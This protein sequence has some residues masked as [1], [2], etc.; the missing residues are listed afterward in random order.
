MYSMPGMARAAFQPVRQLPDNRTE[1]P[2]HTLSSRFARGPLTVGLAAIALLLSASASAQTGT[3]APQI[4][5]RAPAVMLV[6]GN[7]Q[8]TELRATLLTRTPA[9]RVAA[10]QSVLGSIVSSSN[11]GAVTSQL[12]EGVMVVAVGDRT[13]LVLV[14][15]DVD[16]LTGETLEQKGAAAASRL[17]IAVAEQLELR[18]PARL[19]V[20]AVQSV[21]ATIVFVLLLLAIRRGYRV[22]S[23]RMPEGAEAKLQRFSAGDLQLVRA[24][25]AAD[26]LRGFISLVAGSIAVFLTYSWVTFV[27]RRFP[28]TRPWGESLREFLL[29]RLAGVGLLI[30][31]WLPDLFT[32]IVIVLVTR[33]ASR[34]IYV[35]FAAA[36]QDRLKIPAIHPETAP[37]TRRLVIALLWISAFVAS[38]PYLPGSQSDAFKGVSVFV[39]LIVS[40]GSSGIVGQAMSGLTLTYSRAVRIGDFVKIGDVEGT[41]AHLGSLS[42][43]IKTERRED[44]TIPNSVVVSTPITN[45][46]RFADAEGVLNPTTVTIGYDVPWRQVHAML[47]LAAE[48]T[49]NIKR[50]PAPVVRQTGLGNVSV[51]YALLVCLEQPLL[52]SPTLGALRANILDVFNEFGVQIMVPSYEGDPAAP[53]VVRREEWFAAPA[54]PRSVEPFVDDTAAETR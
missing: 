4:P 51:E 10:A 42:T 31:Q 44:V 41:V 20:S 1:T 11:V 32:I 25:K 48:R 16:E 39:G 49:S 40:L 21:A 52:R 19:A 8:I 43:K 7:R 29:S 38:Y 28:Y 37:P 45:Y 27:L 30:V 22:L 12:V 34:F 23:V 3:A 50:Q 14:P 26:I 47:Q 5:S 35:L 54:P 18:T 33:A 17:Q 36:E 9:E 6:Y 24:S 15:D 13:A 46:S 53:K 2:T